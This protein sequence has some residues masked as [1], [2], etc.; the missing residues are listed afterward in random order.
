MNFGDFL[1]FF[2]GGWILVVMGIFGG[3]ETLVLIGCVSV[4]FSF[5]LI[6]PWDNIPLTLFSWPMRSYA[7]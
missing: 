6:R 3:M 4:T 7:I 5:A 2:I 1:L